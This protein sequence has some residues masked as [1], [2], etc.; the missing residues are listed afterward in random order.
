MYNVLVLSSVTVKI[1][2]GYRTLPRALRRIP[3]RHTDRN[4]YYGYPGIHQSP[5]EWTT[6]RIS[7][8]FGEDDRNAPYVSSVRP[9]PIEREGYEIPVSFCTDEGTTKHE[10]ELDFVYPFYRNSSLVFSPISSFQFTI[11]SIK[12]IT[13]IRSERSSEYTLRTK[14]YPRDLTRVRGLDRRCHNENL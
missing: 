13:Y 7:A 5:D 4:V 12:K 6:E 2:W 14:V 8:T 9:E 10:L 1:Q 11:L 3:S